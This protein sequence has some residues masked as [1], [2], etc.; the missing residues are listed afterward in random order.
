MNSKHVY[1][2]HPQDEQDSDDRPQNVNDPVGDGFRLPK[3]EHAAMVTEQGGVS[4]L[5]HP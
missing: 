4:E 5:L 3:V 1:P 2:E